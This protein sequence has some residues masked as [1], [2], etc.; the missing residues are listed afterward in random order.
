MLLVAWFQDMGIEPYKK[1]RQIPKDKRKNLQIV[2]ECEG[3]IGENQKV[4]DSDYGW[5]QIILWKR[6][7]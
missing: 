4:S 3:K 7:R 2:L 6:I 5:V 1:D